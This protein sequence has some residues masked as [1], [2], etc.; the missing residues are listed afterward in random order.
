M[1]KIQIVFLLFSLKIKIILSD[2]YAKPVAARII[3]Y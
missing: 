1:W 2:F 3:F